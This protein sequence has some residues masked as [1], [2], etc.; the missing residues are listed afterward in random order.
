M[1][2]DTSAL[3]ALL[4]NEACAEA[5]DVATESAAWRG[6]SAATLFE[7]A[8]VADG[9]SDP[10]RSARFDALIAGLDI[11]V[12]PLTAAHAAIARQAYRDY[13]RGSGHPAKLN[14]GDC[15]SYALAKERGEPLLY[16]GDD[17]AHTD[18]ASALG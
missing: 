6:I 11:E 13:G 14:F 17:F 4:Q 8:I 7:A 9:T 1:I 5:I 2:V 10:V 3:I 15:F 18:I 16:V 12:V